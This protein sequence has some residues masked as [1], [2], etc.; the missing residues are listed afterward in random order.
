MG[1]VRTEECGSGCQKLG[2]KAPREDKRT[3]HWQADELEPC[4]SGVRTG[5]GGVN[6]EQSQQTRNSEHWNLSEGLL[7]R[8]DCV[9]RYSGYITRGP[10]R[11][12][13]GAALV[14]C[15]E[16]TAQVLLFSYTQSTARI[17]FHETNAG[18]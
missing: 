17:F 1:I 6:P 16:P 10:S 15:Y 18:L 7:S 14:G 4:S 5:S 13:A 11:G 8:F 3:R 12:G 2:R 9:Y